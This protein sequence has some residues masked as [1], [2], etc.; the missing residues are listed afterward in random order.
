MRLAEQT[1]KYSA[2]TFLHNVGIP[3][4][5]DPAHATANNKIILIDRTTLITGSFNFT[6]AAEGK[7]LKLCW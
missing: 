7:T 6:V 2:A 4:L 3:V 5:I 1:A